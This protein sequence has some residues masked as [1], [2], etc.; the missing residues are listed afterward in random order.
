VPVATHISPD[1]R[2]VMFRCSGQIVLSEI[3]RAFDQM[4]SDPGFE[5]GINALWDLRTA[6]IG[7]RV[8]EIPDLLSMI[9]TRQQERGTGYRVAILVEESPDFGLSTLFEMNAHSMPFDVK[10]FRSYTQ[11]TRWLGGGGE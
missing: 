7:V 1:E 5:P 6:S 11:A 4:I 10:V 3:R 2:L 8:Q 9:R